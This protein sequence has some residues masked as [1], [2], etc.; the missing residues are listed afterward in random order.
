MGVSEG[1]DDAR[2]ERKEGRK[3]EGGSGEGNMPS[4]HGGMSPD[5]AYVSLSQL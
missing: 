4:P 5:H 1:D 2:E 3:L